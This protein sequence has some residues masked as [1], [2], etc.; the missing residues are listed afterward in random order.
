MAQKRVII[1]SDPA[2]GVPNRDVDDGL[3]FLLMLAAPEIRVEGITINFGN[4]GALTGYSVAKNLLSLVGRDVPLFKGAE[5]KAD[6]GVLNP[7]VE[8]LIETVRTFPGEVSLLALGPLTNVATALLL[9]PGFAS[10][11]KELVIMGGS[12]HF[13]P[14]S[15]FGE[16]NFHMDGQAAAIA[17]SARV[18]KTLIS[19]DVCSQAV[20]RI[21][22]LHM[23][24]MKNSPVSQYL[25]QAIAP[26]LELN[27]RVFFR[28]KGFFPWDVV[29]AA[30][31][32]DRSLFD[33]NSFSLSVQKTGL[34]SGRIYD[35]RSQIGGP[36]VINVPLRLDSRRFMAMFM[37]ALLSY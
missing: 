5:N 26:W 6:L 8:Y 23:L 9:D 25:V 7:A 4:V 32:I 2:T 10:N 15:L 27:R 14:F 3:A 12:L 11:L 22:Q 28:A 16:F 34:R 17:L 1:D 37:E 21:E 30:Y 33:E 31:L 20:F 19:M 13:K 35:L 24:E 36:D 29:A 18:E